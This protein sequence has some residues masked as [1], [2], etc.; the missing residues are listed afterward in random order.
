MKP[1]AEV[2]V[3][4]GTTDPDA[5]FDF[6]HVPYPTTH[7]HHWSLSN[8][9][10]ELPL[11]YMSE[12]KARRRVVKG[13][14]GPAGMGGEDHAHSQ[15][16]HYGDYYD[17]QGKDVYNKIRPGNARLGSGRLPQRPL[18]PPTSLVS[19]WSS[20]IV[21]LSLNRDFFIRENSS[22]KTSNIYHPSSTPYFPAGHGSTKLAHPTSSSGMKPTLENSARIT[23]NASFIS[24][25]TLLSEK[26]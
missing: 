17:D 12:E 8:R 19:R 4:F 13:P 25:F 11:H 26:C 6:E 9:E 5:S 10:E 3:D 15:K 14:A 20:V 2:A 23:S 24:M 16:E 18:P 7:H 1:P 21:S 22:S